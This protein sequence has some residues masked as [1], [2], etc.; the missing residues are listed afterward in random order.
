MFSPDSPRACAL[1]PRR[2]FFF[3]PVQYDSN[4]VSCHIGAEPL[5]VYHAES[6]R[7]MLDSLQNHFRLCA[8][9]S[10]QHSDAL[11]ELAVSGYEHAQ[12]P[13]SP[14]KV[15]SDGLAL[16]EARLY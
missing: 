3:K 5:Q 6:I 4:P 12:K 8:A 13:N 2:A 7:Q 1:T 9:S 14:Q 10:R 16:D 15:L 11:L